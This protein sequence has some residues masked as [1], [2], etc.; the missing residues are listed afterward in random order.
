MAQRLKDEVRDRILEGALKVF[1]RKGFAAAS[2]A[3]VGKEA[4]VSTGNLYRYYSGKDDLYDAVI[5]PSFVGNLRGLLERRIRSL[6]GVDD[7]GSLPPGSAF[8]LVSGEL[9]GFCLRQRLRVVVLLGR[10]AGT[11]NQG[12]LALLIRQVASR[13]VDHF[14]QTRPGECLTPARRFLLQRLYAHQFDALVEILARQADQAA[15]R[16]A[17]AAL[18]RYHL[19]GLN[20]F[21]QTEG[22]P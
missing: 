12:F 19:A 4:G 2:M 17:I 11:R 3:D 20:A 22:E 18:S 16:D 15:I 10:S 7:V 6:D 14:R 9:L 13:A 8:H 5:P 1:A 21:F